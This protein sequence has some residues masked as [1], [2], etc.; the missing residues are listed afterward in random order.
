[1]TSTTLSDGRIK[2]ITPGWTGY[3]NPNEPMTKTKWFKD[4]TKYWEIEGTKNT[5]V[6]SCDERNLLK[7]ECLGFTYRK[8]CKHITQVKEMLNGN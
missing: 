2:H 4:G 1:M 5:Y 3:Q 6:V 8:R 7:C